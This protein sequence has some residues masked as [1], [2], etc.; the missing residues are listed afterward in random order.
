MNVSVSPSSP[1]TYTVIGT[2]ANGCTGRAIVSVGVYPQPVVT[3]VAGNNDVCAGEP[4]TLTGNGAVSYL[5]H[6]TSPAVLLLGQQVSTAIHIN[7]TFTVTGTDANGCTDTDV[8]MMNVQACTGIEKLVRDNG[9][10]VF[11]NPT[12]GEF[13]VA[14]SGEA[15]VAIVDVAGRTLYETKAA[16]VVNV[17]ITGFAAGVYYAKV[18]I[19]GTTA[20]IK[21]IKE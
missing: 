4:F 13:T 11:P 1:S 9:L 5:W 10:Q 3:G 2:S 12:S 6:S 18:S 19:N 7:T 8:V 17:D 20:A 16:D 21:I 15:A 14:F